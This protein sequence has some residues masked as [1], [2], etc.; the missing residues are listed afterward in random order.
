MSADNQPSQNENLFS[1]AS[2]FKV[3]LFGRYTLFNFT[4]S[5]QLT[6]AEL[7]IVNKPVEHPAFLNNMSR[8]EELIENHSELLFTGVFIFIAPLLF[9]L[10]CIADHVTFD[11]MDI[12]LQILLVG[13]VALRAFATF[14]IAHIAAEQGRTSKNW[15]VLAAILP[16]T[17]LLL[18]GLTS[19]LTQPYAYASQHSHYV[20]DQSILGKIATYEEK[21]ELGRVAS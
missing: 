7:S 11:A 15:M 17:S 14:W 13:G 21:V 18:I 2:N 10:F 20:K 1:Y 16:G 3:K 9:I 6:P 5:V 4:R 19:K 8:M 12:Y